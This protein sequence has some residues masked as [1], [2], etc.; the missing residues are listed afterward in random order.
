M[1]ALV[2]EDDKELQKV[3]IR[4]LEKENFVCTGIET[5]KEAVP[6]VKKTRFYLYLIDVRLKDG[7]GL[8]LCQMIRD[9]NPGALILVNTANKVE[10][11]VVLALQR[12][13]DDYIEKT[14]KMQEMRA[15]IQMA[16]KRKRD[17]ETK[18]VYYSG[19]IKLDLTRKVMYKEL[20][21][22]VLTKKEYNIATTIMTAKGRIVSQDYLLQS[23]MD[24][25]DRAKSSGTLSTHITH[26]RQ[27]LGTWEG[28]GYIEARYGEGFYWNHRVD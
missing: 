9:L 16:V 20:K 4:I 22:V 3:L 1:R 14:A 19:D 26:I 6:L 28:K 15:R 11:D 12:G 13:A 8:S 18:E 2:I 10:E 5:L 23:F 24:T 27:K 25:A 17:S 21:P 7:S